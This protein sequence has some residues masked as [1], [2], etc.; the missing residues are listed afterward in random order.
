MMGGRAFYGG[1]CLS[2]LLVLRDVQL[3]AVWTSVRHPGHQSSTCAPVRK[4]GET[5]EGPVE[6]LL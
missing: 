2:I 1:A 4:H 3:L 5:M 6:A